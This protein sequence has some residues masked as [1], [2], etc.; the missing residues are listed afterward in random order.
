MASQS[1]H[2][3]QAAQLAPSTDGEPAAGDSCDSSADRNPRSTPPRQSAP[4]GLNPKTAEEENNV[5]LRLSFPRK[6]WRIVEDAAFTST[7]WNDEVIEVDLSQMEV[8][9]RRGL[10]QIFETDSI[11]SFISELNL[12]EFSKIHPLGR[13]AGKKMMMY[14]QE[15]GKKVHK[16]TPPAH[17]TPSWCSFVIVRRAGRNHLPSEQGSP[18]GEG[19]SSNAT[20]VPPATFGRDGTGELPKSPSEYPDYNLVMTL[21]K[22][23]YSILMVALSVMAPNEAPEVEEEQGESLDY[24]CVLCALQG[25]A[26][27]LNC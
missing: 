9:Q 4:Q 26:Q 19:T 8:L 22:T 12:Y 20:S 27:S 18:S 6:L 21:H 15:A 25:Q 11:K 23:C 5:I 16:G 14:T 2:E 10:D 3:A 24:T 7:C 1:S 17:R 13:F